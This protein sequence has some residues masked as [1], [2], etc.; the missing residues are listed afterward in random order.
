MSHQ[1]VAFPSWWV[2]SDI[3]WE[4]ATEIFNLML[5]SENNFKEFGAKLAGYCGAVHL[6]SGFRLACPAGGIEEKRA[7]WQASMR[8]QHVN[9]CKYKMKLHHN[10]TRF[11]NNYL[12]ILEG[13]WHELRQHQMGQ[14]RNLNSEAVRAVHFNA[15]G[16][17]LAKIVICCGLALANYDDEERR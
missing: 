15:P 3:Y 10:Q 11:L 14:L 17:G 9:P 7:A 16:T 8:L 12:D 5:K 1:F 2:H 6:S 13:F 4:R